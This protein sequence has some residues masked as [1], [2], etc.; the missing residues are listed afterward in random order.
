MVKAIIFDW[1]GVLD[2]I[3]FEDLV[4]KIVAIKNAPKDSISQTL[5]QYGNDY[6]RGK[7]PSEKF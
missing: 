1:H 4:D 5:R 3:K 2:K 7:L 6:A